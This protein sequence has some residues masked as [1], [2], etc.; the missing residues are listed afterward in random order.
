ML[1]SLNN[2]EIGMAFIPNEEFWMKYGIII[3][4]MFLIEM[5]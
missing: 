3:R 4:Y 1:N 2:S 5:L